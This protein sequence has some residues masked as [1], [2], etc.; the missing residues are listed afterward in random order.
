VAGGAA[1]FAM[2]LVALVL[3]FYREANVVI[4]HG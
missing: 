4:P 2:L 3:L 1:A